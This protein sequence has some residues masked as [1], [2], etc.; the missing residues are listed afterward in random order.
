[1]TMTALSVLIVEDDALIGRLLAEILEDM[2]HMVCAIVATED[3]AV[4]DAMRH[5]PGLMIVD[6]NLQ[7]GNGVSAVD[8]IL[9]NGPKPYVLMSGVPMQT[10][11]PNATVLRKPF[12][13][14]DLA[15]AIQRVIGPRS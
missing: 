11:R 5:Q 13:E 4:A 7:E 9:K 8:R 1:M 2:G 12:N 10:G 6:L 15:Q 3:E 14:Q